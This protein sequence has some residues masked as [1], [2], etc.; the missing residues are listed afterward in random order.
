MRPPYY[1][2]LE[3]IDIVGV[4]YGRRGAVW[5]V[6]PNHRANSSISAT[7]PPCYSFLKEI[8]ILG[9]IYGGLVWTVCNP[10]VPA[11]VR[12]CM[13]T[14]TPAGLSGHP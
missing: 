2:F 8:V 9:A 12:E 10:V 7:R 1:P 11:R 5:D 14:V 13:P 3:E 6:R 4:I